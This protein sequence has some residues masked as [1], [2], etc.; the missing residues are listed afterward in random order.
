M[1]MLRPLGIYLA[2]CG[3][4]L[5]THQPRLFLEYAAFH[6]LPCVVLDAFAL[7]SGMRGPEIAATSAAI[8]C[9]LFGATVR[10]GLQGVPQSVALGH[11]RAWSIRSRAARISAFTS[12][13]SSRRAA[14]CPPAQAFRDA[15]AL[16]SGVRGPV[17]CFHGVQVRISAD[18]F[19]LRFGVQAVAMLVLQ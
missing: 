4:V 5:V 11:A 9:R 2:T 6:C 12:R 7:P 14:R 10:G 17:A 15:V 19:A 1:R 13:D 18:C 16:P 8:G 3:R